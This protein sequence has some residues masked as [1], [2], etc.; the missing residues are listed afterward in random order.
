MSIL[1]K[2]ISAI[3]PLEDQEARVEAR[4]K[5][6]STAQ[7]GDWLAKVVE[8]HR[9]IETQFATL[10]AAGTS[11]ERRT[12]Q[13]ELGILLTAHSI[14]E[15][16]AL[17]PAMAAHGQVAHA[18]LAYQEQSAAKMELGLLE[19]LDPDSEDYHDKLKH[20]ESAVLHHVYSE[21]GTWFIDLAQSVPAAEQATM[22]ERYVEEYERYMGRTHI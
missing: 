1:D 15:E 20:I 5:A 3:L 10:A 19:R 6:E 9:G 4:V 18:E 11:E 22:Q 16:A 13:E 14:A 12:A 2:A 7:P 21:E 17:Y 8:H